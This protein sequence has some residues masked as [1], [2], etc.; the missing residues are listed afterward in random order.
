[1]LSAPI[2]ADWVEFNCYDNQGEIVHQGKRS[3]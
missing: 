2:A 1:M 3:L